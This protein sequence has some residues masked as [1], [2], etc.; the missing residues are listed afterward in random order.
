MTFF[1]R[2]P[3][4]TGSYTGCWLCVDA[5]LAIGQCRLGVHGTC[6]LINSWHHKRKKSSWVRNPGRPP[7]VIPCGSA[8]LKKS[9]FFSSYWPMRGHIMR[10]S[11]NFNP[12][13]TLSAGLVPKTHTHT[14]KRAMDRVTQFGRKREEFW[15]RNNST[16][17]LKF[18]VVLKTQF[19]EVSNTH[20]QYINWFP[21]FSSFVDGKWQKLSWVFTMFFYPPITANCFSINYTKTINLSKSWNYHLNLLGFFLI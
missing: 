18:T 6:G 2:V 12:A 20:T 8:G 5:E 1:V 17:K 9:T 15:R 21:S 13:V 3:I 16:E 11:R 19:S 10:S 7:Y 14:H 4:K